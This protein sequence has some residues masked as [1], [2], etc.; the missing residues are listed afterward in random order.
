MSEWLFEARPEMVDKL[1]DILKSW[2]HTPYRHYC[3]VKK[4]G[5]DCIHFVLR[6]YE[7]LGVVAPRQIKIPYY[8]PDWHLHREE[9]LLLKTFMTH[10]IVR[11]RVRRVNPN[12]PL[13]GDI[14]IMKYG[15]VDSHG[16]IY[17]GSR[18]WHAITKIGVQASHVCDRMWSKRVTHAF[19][20]VAA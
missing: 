7:E 15:R 4:K 11:P 18:V 8:P 13:E 3:G 1:G 16:G 5:V 2:E 20:V 9:E 19:R 12:E 14:I 6:V 17:Y 10:P